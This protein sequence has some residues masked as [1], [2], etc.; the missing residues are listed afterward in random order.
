YA[1]ASL[2]HGSGFLAV[3]I[4]GILLGDERLPYKGEIE[5]FSASLAS[6]AELVV[7]VV[8]GLTVQ[9]GSLSGRAW[10][11]GVVLAAGTALLIRPPV[12]ALTLAR[13][14]LTRPERAFIAWGGLKGAVP[15]LLAAF[16]VLER[17]DGA[18]R[19]YAVVFVVVLASVAGQGT[20]VPFVAR[21]LGIPMR[22]RPSLPWE[23]SIRL[24]TEPHPD[25][26]LIVGAGSRAAGRPIRH[27][28][29]GEHAWITLV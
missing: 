11:D 28:P 18:A 17:V 5:R 26:E 6:L 24:G 3:F 15:I 2:A 23:L 8:L 4:A 20:L 19:L 29:L 25:H 10:L 21:R 1:G 12:V 22:N 9:I 7:F 16:A 27:L 13:A 14:R